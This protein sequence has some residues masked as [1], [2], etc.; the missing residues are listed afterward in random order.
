MEPIKFYEYIIKDNTIKK[1]EYEADEENK[2]YYIVNSIWNRRFI[3]KDDF[4]K[5][6]NN[7]I[8]SYEDDY[9]KYVRLLLIYQEQKVEKSR[10]TYEQQLATFEEL[11][12][13]IP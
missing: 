11:K 6:Y 5:I 10:K 2:G 8:L 1:I 3:D 12:K 4:G 9:D 13:L 7:R